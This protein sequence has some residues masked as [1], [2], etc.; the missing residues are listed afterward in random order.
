M[1]NL[2]TK[3]FQISVLAVS[4]SLVGCVTMPYQPYARDVKKK[5]QSG[6]VVA[7]K[8][9]H[10]DEDRAK[11]Q[12]M[13][14]RTCQPY[15]V[16]VLEEGEVVVGQET[17]T[18]GNT[19]YNEGAK[20]SQVGNLFGIPVISGQKDPS[21]ATETASSTTQIKEWQINYECEKTSK[22]ASR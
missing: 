14:A 3:L 20:G 12:S 9:D 2:V 5:G 19:S 21:Q 4:V 7:M 18:K 15:T 16:K 17:T 6:G 11:A 22:R 8:L 13:M 1:K 10:R